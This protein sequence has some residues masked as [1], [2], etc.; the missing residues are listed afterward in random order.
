LINMNEISH[1]K[2]GKSPNSIEMNLVLTIFGVD[3]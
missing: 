2:V 3:N 1:N